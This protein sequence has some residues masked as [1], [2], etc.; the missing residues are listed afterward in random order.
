[1]GRKI[2]HGISLVYTTEVH[3]AREIVDLHIV[4]RF[5]IIQFLFTYTSMNSKK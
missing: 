4:F 2:L 1:M 3:G 5:H